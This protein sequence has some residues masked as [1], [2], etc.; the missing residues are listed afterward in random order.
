[1]GPT[2]VDQRLFEWM[3]VIRRTL[4]RL[5]ELSYDEFNTSLLIQSKLDELGLTYRTGWGG[6]GV[7]ATLANGTSAH[8]VALRAD[9]DALPIQDGKTVPYAST[10]P[11]VMHAC[12][13]DGHVAML[14]GAAALLQKSTFSGNVTLIFQP[15]EEHGNGAQ[16]LI[17]EGVLQPGIE[18]V[19]AG[20]IDIHYPTGVITVDEGLICSFTDPF[21]LKIQ[22]QGGHAARPHE[23]RDAIVAGAHLVTALQTL[24]SR[25]TDPNHSA[26]LTIGRFVGGQAHNVIAGEATLE[27]TIRTNNAEARNRIITGLQ[28][29][30]RQAGQQFNVLIQLDFF[31]GLPAVV[32]S[33]EAARFARRAAQQVVGIENVISQGK[34]SLGGEDFSF[35]QQFVEGC[36]VRFGAGTLSESGPSHSSTFDFD[37]DVL[38][39]GA[40]WLAQAALQWLAGKRGEENG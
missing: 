11:G 40:A 20:H 1:M 27:G 31:D 29:M 12:G 28:R 15:A 33:P 17:Q 21:V 18:A 9:M 4:H 19:F 32:N 37:E 14:L 10:V 22:G 26:V 35:Y 6:T 2:E 8:H 24:V 3:R 34:P 38:A 39:V 25:E 23:A 7:T 16:R 36:L 5:P 13:H 30:V